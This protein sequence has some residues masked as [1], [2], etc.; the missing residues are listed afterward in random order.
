MAHAQVGDTAPEF[1]LDGTEGRFRLSDHRGQTVVL[2]FYPGDDT[3]VCTKQLCEYS[4]HLDELTGL[5]EAVV[6]A[7]SAKDV[8]SKE[9]FRDK[10]G[11]TVPLLADPDRRVAAL[12]GAKAPVIGTKRSTFVIDAAGVVRWRHDSALGISFVPVAELKAQVAAAGAAGAP[13]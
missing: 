11:L 7:I 1:E 13:A 9:R 10:H 2:A 6:V 4:S 3:K 12:Y 5:G 8:A